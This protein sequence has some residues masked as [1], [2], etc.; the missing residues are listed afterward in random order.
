METALTTRPQE[1][2]EDR[3]IRECAMMGEIRRRREEN[4]RLKAEIEAHE[5]R[6]KRE[7]AARMAR[8]RREIEAEKQQ[9]M[10]WMIA[11]RG[12]ALFMAGAGCAALMVALAIMCVGG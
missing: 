1:T 6:R 8:Y 12:V 4:A 11:V 5:A 2:A 10:R 7:R 9:D 3:I